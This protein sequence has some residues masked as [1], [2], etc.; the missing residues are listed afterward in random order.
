M[1]YKFGPGSSLNSRNIWHHHFIE[2]RTSS[3]E[4]YLR[5]TTSR[6]DGKDRGK[7]ANAGF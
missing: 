4:K 1:F 2:V 5:T 3:L 6:K 7:Y